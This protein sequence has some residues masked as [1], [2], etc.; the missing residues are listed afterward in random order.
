MPY[1][2]W[3]YTPG[4]STTDIYGSESSQ[5]GWNVGSRSRGR[6]DA[7]ERRMAGLPA[8]QFDQQKKIQNALLGFLG[9]DLENPQLGQPGER[10]FGGGDL[11]DTARDFMQGS[12]GERMDLLENFGES[13]RNRL[14]RDLEDSRGTVGAHLEA[15]GLGSSNLVGEAQSSVDEGYQQAMLGLEDALLGNKL[16]TI[17]G[18]D[19][20]IFGSYG[21]QAS[22]S[23]GILQSLLGLIR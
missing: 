21:D 18:A 6:P 12:K 5:G 22:L 7:L 17:S 8:E 15:R 11:F 3:N 10:D 13:Q 14:A 19:D 9:I 2:S 4:S 1:A 20:A 23:S 16:E